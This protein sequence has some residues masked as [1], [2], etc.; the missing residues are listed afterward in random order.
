MYI[1]KLGLVLRVP[2]LTTGAFI[3]M[4]A[5]C[6]KLCLKAWWHLLHES[7]RAAL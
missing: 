1:E 7:W 2:T 4:I 3:S 6:C 5:V